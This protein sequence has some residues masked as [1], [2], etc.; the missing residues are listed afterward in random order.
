[1]T[2]GTILGAVVIAVALVAVPSGEPDPAYTADCAD[3]GTATHVQPDTRANRA[4]ATQWC[5][6]LAA[7]QRADQFARYIADLWGK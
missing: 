4:A 3:D 6:E 7:F 1:M 5:A 2:A